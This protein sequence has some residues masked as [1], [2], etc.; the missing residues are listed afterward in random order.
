MLALYRAGRQA[1]A[2]EAYQDARRA[3]V[4]ELG[5]EP[6]KSLREL[7]QAILRQDPALDPADEGVDTGASPLQETVA[8]LPVEP[9]MEQAQRKERKVVTVL[10]ADLVG[11][12]ARAEALDPEDVEAILRPYHD[13]LRSEL[14]RHGGTVE[15]FIGDA[16]M[17]LFGAPRAHE[18]DPERAVRAALAIRDWAREGGKL[19]V[20]IGIT[21]GEA[22]VTL[23]ARPDAGEGMASGDIVNTAARLES[24]A[25]ASRILVDEATF[26]ATERAIEY[27][28]A[29]PVEAKGKSEPVAVWEPLEAR[30]RVEVEVLRPS[31]PLVG[32]ER[33]RELVLG[34]LAR[35]KRERSPQLVTLV[36]VPGIGKSRMVAELFAEVE[37]EPE[38]VSWRQGRSLSYGEG[39]AFWAF[40]EMVK[41]QAGILHTDAEDVAA[42]KLTEAVAAA[43]EAD[44][45]WVEARL[46]P[47]V[48]LG[49]RAE[50]RD[51]SFTA[52]SR[53]VEALAEE[54]PM[55]LVFEDLH[56]AD[57]DLLDFVDYL[58]DW[59]SGV[60]LL[61]VGTA[62]PELLE[63]R[64][65]W[66]GGKRDAIT[67]SL[68]PLDELETAR[69]ISAL[70]DRAVLPTQTEESILR[71]SGGNPLYAEQYVRMFAERGDA[72]EL[73]PETVQGI[74]AARVDALSPAE[75]GLLQDAS[76]LGKVFWT[77]ALEAV[78]GVERRGAESILHG[79]E[80][81]EFVRRERRSSVEGETEHAFAHVLVRDVAY[82]Q[83]P[84]AA[85]AE[86]HRLAAEWIDSLGRKDDHADMLAHHYARAL[87]FLA[88]TGR[89]DPA[90]AEHTRL[91]LRAAG[92]RALALASYAPAVRYYRAALDLWPEDDPDR[93][94]LLAQAGRAAEGADGMGGDLLEQAFAAL[95]SNG[96]ADG[97][98]EVAVDLA[99][100]AWNAGDRDA[101]DAYVDRALELA[102]D[103]AG[104]PAR[105]HALVA[106][107]GYH[108]VASEYGDAIRV[109]REALPLTEALQM[110]ALRARTL[111]VLGIARVLIGDSGGLDDLTK[112]IALAREANAFAQLIVAE[113]NL[114]SAHFCLGQLDAA[115]ETL[116]TH[117]RDAERY[118]DAFNRAWARGSGAYEDVLQ[119]RWDRATE[120]LDELISVAES[121][122]AHYME[123]AW[124]ALR[125]SVELARGELSAASSDSAKGLERARAAK[126]PQSVAP[127][128][129]LRGM[130]LVAQ[131][132]STEAS[133]L[134]SE[135]LAFGAVLVSGLV[136][137]SP[138]A[139]LIE[140]AWLLRALG[141]EAEL[142][143]VLGSV[144]STPWAEAAH[145]LTHGDFA[146]GAELVAAIGAPSVEAYTRLRLAEEFTTA[147]RSAE[148]H[149]QIAL[150]L[151][152]FRKV[153]AT[154]YIAQAE[155]LLSIPA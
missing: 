11:F 107:A 14:E 154:R 67:I 93:A 139:T 5:I 137:E 49:E 114:R 77:G 115:W 101:A 87:E 90:L 122:V 22:L 140:F 103:N 99:R 81:K 26:R 60:P 8:P 44:A 129:A 119:G 121:G 94:W 55:V 73:L 130:V 41:A 37:R 92:D 147:G 112:A 30:S 63:R 64:P 89:E 133:A 120:V 56:W 118:A 155:E 1:E 143:A 32:R 144:P 12:T 68:A 45:S 47:L 88:A 82:S 150:A 96:D 70:L 132:R 126:D 6:G 27:A 17:A 98:A 108:M 9:P 109:A 20:R 10:F 53:F 153:G 31:T 100:G 72:G 75:K 124:Y 127:A 62:R 19:E 34:A 117:R 78:S 33:E 80:R 51:E 21:T 3:L 123:P 136:G 111:D 69:L 52:W 42:A 25:P 102:Q 16:V 86:R 4:A 66:G 46:R 58:V 141:R 85:R 148:A 15:K 83:I 125:A 13:R 138:A 35:A 54:R 110:Q 142:G 95:Q 91:A 40:A 59:I 18:D 7:E 134:S 97:A 113:D 2:L 128:L 152:F 76:V 23:G 65:G 104:S 135:V 50:D 43:L 28:E 131:G 74:I 36:G 61:V 57:D 146:H 71:R 24:A 106:R 39:V 105:A 48:G 38:L 151:P 29:E 116:A 84:R 145:A 79:L 149:D